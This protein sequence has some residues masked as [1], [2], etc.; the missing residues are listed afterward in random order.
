MLDNWFNGGIIFITDNIDDQGKIS[1]VVILQN[2]ICQQNWISE[3]SIVTKS[4]MSTKLDIRNIHSYKIRPSR[5]E[6]INKE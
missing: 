5:M 6:T 1:E 4:Y 3:T 2:L